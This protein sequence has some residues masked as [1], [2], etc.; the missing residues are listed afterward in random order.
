MVVL[1]NHS[2]RFTSFWQANHLSTC[3]SNGMISFHCLI[4][5]CFDV[6]IRRVLPRARPLPLT[7]DRR[8]SRHTV[9]L[10]SFLARRSFTLAY[11]LCG[12]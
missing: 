5:S 2:P 4:S 11:D 8:G 6:Y 9:T 3:S 1:S 12:Y 7:R 10:S